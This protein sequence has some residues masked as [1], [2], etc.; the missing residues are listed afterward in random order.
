MPSPPNTVCNQVKIEHK[1]ELVRWLRDTLHPADNTT[2]HVHFIDYDTPRDLA[3]LDTAL[4]ND[5][6]STSSDV[7]KLVK[8]I[9]S[10]SLFTDG[11]LLSWSGR[12]TTAA[13]DGRAPANTVLHSTFSKLAKDGNFHDFQKERSVVVTLG[14]VPQG[15]NGATETSPCT[16]H[17]LQLTSPDKNLAQVTWQTLIT[18]SVR[19]GDT[20]P[21]VCVLVG[22]DTDSLKTAVTAVSNNIPVIVMKGSGGFADLLAWLYH[23]ATLDYTRRRVYGKVQT[24][25]VRVVEGETM[26]KI[27]THFKDQPEIVTSLDTL[28]SNLQLLTVYTPDKTDVSQDNR[29]MDAVLLEALIKHNQEAQ[30]DV[31]LRTMKVQQKLVHVPKHTYSPSVVE[32]NKLQLDYF[33]DSLLGR[34]PAAVSAFL[35]HLKPN[36]FDFHLARLLRLYEADVRFLQTDKLGEEDRHKPFARFRQARR[37]LK[38]YAG[39]VSRFPLRC[40]GVKCKQCNLGDNADQKKATGHSMQDAK[41]HFLQTC[42]HPIQELFLWALLSGNM[43]LTVSLWKHCDDKMAAALFA[44]AVYLGIRKK[45]TNVDVK[46]ELK[47]YAR[48][49]DDLAVATLKASNELHEETTRELINKD[50]PWW[51]EVSVLQLAMLTRSKLFIAQEPCRQQLTREWDGYHDQRRMA[52]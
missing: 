22:G 13:R 31:L 18:T 8:D 41:A 47:D 23:K 43:D 42:L 14:Y 36:F 3:D 38:S 11:V 30:I 50:C 4:S 32:I 49:F 27:R 26:K 15:R 39:S 44:R 6:P 28:V 24:V 2:L 33:I 16:R 46:K 10:L 21:V 25:T 12:K 35:T 17:Q 29:N 45:Q 52:D 9:K 5:Q 19:E 7:K 40:R 48:R 20:R 34:S 51:G 1:A 37:D